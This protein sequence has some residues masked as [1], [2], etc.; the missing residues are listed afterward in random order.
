MA[1]VLIAGAVFSAT[2]PKNIILMISDGCGYNQILAT[3]FYEFGMT[4]TQVY[5]KF[6]FTSAMSTFQTND[7]TGTVAG[8][9]EGGYAP[10][11][12]WSW[13][14]YIKQKPTD[15]ASSATAFSTGVRTYEGAICVDA[16]QN[17]LE[18][19]VQ[20]AEKLG[21]ATGVVSSV[22]L[23]HATP[24][25]MVAHNPNRNDYAGIANEMFYVSGLD[26]IAA[27]GNPEFDDDGQPASKDAKYVGGA[28]T[29]AALKAGTAGNDSDGDGSFDPWT[30][31]TDSAAIAS[32]QNGGTPKRV[33]ICPEVYS[34]L[35]Q[36][37]SG[38]TLGADVVSDPY[39]DPMNSGVPSLEQMT[40]ASLNVLDNDED[41]FFVMVEGGAIDWA[42]HA[43]ST[44]R[45]IEEE[46]DFNNSVE[47][48]VRW[49]NQNSSWDETLLIVTGD[50][51]C[52][53]LTGL[54]SGTDGADEG[55]ET[56]VFTEPTNN[57][58]GNLPGTEWHS[59]N[60]T[61]QLIPL[62][63]KGPGIELLKQ[64]ADEFD[65]VRGTYLANSEVGQTFFSLWPTPEEDTAP[66]KNIILL[67]S[68]GCGYNQIL[69][70]DYYEFG[71]AGTQVY[72][73]FPVQY[74]MSTFQARDKS[75]TKPG[76]VEGAYEPD[77]A[78]SWFDYIK[79]KPTD[80]ASSATAFST[81]V[82]SYEGAICVDA[83]MNPL[84][85]IVEVAEKKGKATGVVSSVEFSHATPAGMVAHNPNRN[86]Y[87]SIAKE[88]I[89]QSGLDLI[90]ACGNPEFDD[91]G[92]PASKDAKYVGGAETWADLK[93]GTAG[94]DADGDGVFDAWTLVT[95]SAAIAALQNGSTPKRVLICPQVY[96]TLQ[97][98]RSGSTKGADVV[99][100][101][102]TDPLSNGVPSL[103]Q[104]TKASL[105]VLDNDQDGFFVMI[106]GGAIDWAG[107]ANST[108]RMIEEEIDFN[109]TV[110]AVVQWVNQN[111]NWNE[112]LVI[113]TG[114]HEC[115]FLTGIGSG[116]DGAAEGSETPVFTEPANNGAGNLPGTEWHSTNHTN[117]LIP[118]FAKGAGSTKIQ[119]Y[120]DNYD[121]VRGY[122]VDNAEMGQLM[123]SLMA[124]NDEGTHFVNGGQYQ[125][126]SITDVPN[127][128]GGQVRI[129]WNAHPD[130]QDG[131]IESYS[132][133]RKITSL[134]KSIDMPA[135][136][137]DF[138]IEVPAS[139]QTIYRTVVPTL[140]DSTLSKGMAL[141]TF[142]II[143]QTSDPSVS[144]NTQVASGYSVD[145]L[146]PAPLQNVLLAKSVEGNLLSWNASEESD[147]DHYEIY[148][149]E[150]EDFVPCKE[151]CIASL[152]ATEYLDKPANA[153]INYYYK[154][155][156]LDFAGN[157]TVSGIEG[158]TAVNPEA[159]PTT[160]GL[161]QNYPNP[162]NP[163][164]TIKFSLPQT[165]HV[166]LSIFNMMGQHVATLIDGEKIAG[167][168]DVVWDAAGMSSGL[169]MCKLEAGS[170]MKM[171]KMHLM[172]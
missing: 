148:R 80:S 142:M 58:A 31:V 101:P 60:H 49:V 74:P 43:N 136:Q 19:I 119:R 166:K 50:H 139:A 140:C 90:A 53:Y 103:A 3:D 135:G 78:W 16:E 141:S 40:T 114:D 34:T 42:G 1:F 67:I 168:Y 9:V 157:A 37:R 99:S 14:D 35:Q 65:Q 59:T 144:Y 169:Y 131:L 143:A 152:A 6:D 91:D 62:F 106:E 130:D 2:T 21:K 121:E 36:S 149:S 164:T 51:E 79:Q 153:G 84:Q 134:A 54:G 10:D 71:R 111:S 39:T 92:Q 89:Y 15:S 118:L 93:A 69:A 95:D 104:M 61:N 7:K 55:S 108:A 94:N 133:F 170:F 18:T 126:V 150:T 30:L 151:N 88:M 122:F 124:M 163:T 5:E 56:P 41:G 160:F 165:A 146:S 23:S 22:P 86:E 125:I 46:I 138:V 27:C 57:G 155:A 113:V 20:R 28:D 172:K 161:L 11:R 29:W 127:D 8:P 112:T 73:Q 63:A 76:A 25:G 87:A 17:P 77:R 33:L 98:S 158:T 44:A 32:L 64:H 72:E 110:E 12:A 52:G 81:G 159:L 47:A 156:V 26:L 45:M 171:M 154:V 132:I 128:Q 83:E 116:T 147:F 115:G 162:F 120:A 105:N 4:G 167:S 129:E 107:H 102:Y 96:S 66:P 100:A 75:G 85:T 123:L 117:Q 137:W 82:K 48:V 70:T 13:F 68:D 24:A 38:S 97:Q 109:N 145:N